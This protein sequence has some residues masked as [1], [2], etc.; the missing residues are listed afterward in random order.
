MGRWA[1]WRSVLAAAVFA[2]AVLVG[3]PGQ[4]VASEV[5][6]L[7]VA[8]TND[9][10]GYY[11]QKEDACVGLVGVAAMVDALEPQLVLDAGDT[12]HGQSFAT[13][14][15]GASVAQLMGL[16]GY[17]ATTPG[18]H[19][20]SYGAERLRELAAEFG[21]PVLASNVL[22]ADG[23]AF[24][25][26]PALVK[27][28]ELTA[29]DGSRTTVT[30]GVLGVIDDTFYNSTAAKNVAGLSFADP[31]ASANEAAAELRAQGVDVV[32]ALTHSRDPQ[33]FAA[34]TEG[35]DAVVAGHEHIK[36]DEAV[37]SADGRT[38]PV[39]EAGCYLA[40][41]G[42][43]ELELSRDD[44]T[45]AHEVT[46]HEETVYDEAAVRGLVA[47]S[48][49]ADQA[50]DAISDIEAEQQEILSEVIATS[51]VDYPSSWEAVRSEH[52][53]IGDVITAAY[54]DATG[55]DLAFE[56]AGGI[57]GGIAAGNVTVGTILAISP[58]GNTLGTYTMSG[59]DVLAVL[60]DSLELRRQCAEAWENQKAAADAGMG[61]DEIYETYPFP[62]SSGSV[63]AVGGVT[64]AIDWARPAGSR[65]VSAELADGRAL[66]SEGSYT[67]AA[68]SYVPQLSDD[69]PELRMEE[70]ADWGTCEQVLRAFVAQDGWE[71]RVSE[72]AGGERDYEA[73]KPSEDEK[74][75]EGEVPSEGEDAEPGAPNGA[76]PDKKPSGNI[77]ATG[78]SASAVPALLAGA[79]GASVAVAA[80]RRRRAA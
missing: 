2:V 59:A 42:V 12:F 26:T 77:P 40:G 79:G 76:Q 53:A 54:L 75:P 39:V 47:T 65:I 69:Y 30:V 72:L 45:G 68:N 17:D 23:G 20:W 38:V 61:E 62:E 43:L 67:V 64:L 44:E 49:R 46:G 1:R 37:T 36:I 73:E 71:A 14:S 5:G 7:S 56:N 74:E 55:A 57:R 28:V 41:V 52:T 66:T 51:S 16:I 80:W 27:D 10:H 8:H 24:F 60:E 63:L 48:E 9:M 29:E 78:D 58:Y 11:A 3:V 21:V 32:I 18:N 25:S 31:A 70:V 34:A 13:V 35:I 19:D 50:A 22:T 33:A 6:T 4:A 15:E